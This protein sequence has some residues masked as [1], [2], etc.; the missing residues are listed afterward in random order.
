MV[1]LK[2]NEVS[3]LEL[4]E[5]WKNKNSKQIESIKKLAYLSKCGI[6]N[7]KKIINYPSNWVEFLRELYKYQIVSLKEFIKEENYG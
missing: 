7:A 2:C 5:I 1:S 6:N 3:L 4:K